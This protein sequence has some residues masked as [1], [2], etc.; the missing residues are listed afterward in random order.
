MATSF[1]KSLSESV[2]L[3][4]VN[5]LLKQYDDDPNYRMNSKVSKFRGYSVDDLKIVR[6]EIHNRRRG[7]S[8]LDDFSWEREMEGCGL[9]SSDTGKL[10]SQ[11]YLRL[12]SI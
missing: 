1:L 9:G 3:Q 6:D 4:T 10:I 7:A 5:M 11:L 2:D 8:P 12:G